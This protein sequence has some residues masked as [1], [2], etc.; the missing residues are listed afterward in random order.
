MTK[1]DPTRRRRGALAASFVATVS[2]LAGCSSTPVTT[3]VMTHNP[4]RP[5][6][7]IE[8]TNPP[9]PATTTASVE[10]PPDKIAIALPKLSEDE[11]LGRNADGTCWGHSRL[12]ANPPPPPREV[13]CPELPAAPAGAHVIKRKDGTCWAAPVINCPKPQNGMPRPTCNPPAPHRVKCK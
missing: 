5:T 7:T 13:Q 10:P 9:P 3:P 12:R 8:A 11:Y 4:P 1:P 2:T 6:A